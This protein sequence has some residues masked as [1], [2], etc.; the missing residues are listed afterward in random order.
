MEE[1]TNTTPLALGRRFKSTIPIRTVTLLFNINAIKAWLS[2]ASMCMLH[3]FYL[4]N[5]KN[6]FLMFGTL[7]KE[8]KRSSVRM[9]IV[10]SGCDQCVRPVGVVAGYDGWVWH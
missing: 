2:L 1:H 4:S 6:I 3:L 8:C 7:Q 9:K 5:I 10:A